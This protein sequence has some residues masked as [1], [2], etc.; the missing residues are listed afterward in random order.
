VVLIFNETSNMGINPQADEETSMSKVK[1]QLFAVCVAVLATV[2]AAG[3]SDT[4]N[5][6]QPPP[7]GTVV[8]SIVVTP[9]STSLDR[10]GAK[11]QFDAQAFDANGG[12]MSATFSWASTNEN[13]VVIG[14]GGL[15]AASGPGNAYIIASAGGAADS[16]SV[17]VTVGGSTVIAW[18]AGVNGN[19]DDATKWD[20]GEVPGPDDTAVIDAAGDYTV[21]MAGDVSIKSLILGDPTVGTPSLV[22]GTNTL[23]VEGGSING[24]A[25]LDVDGTTNITGEFDWRGGDIRGTG[26]VQIDPS[27]ELEIGGSGA[28]QDLEATLRNRGTVAVAE[29][30]SIDLRGGNIENSFGA[31]LDF[32]GDGIISTLAN[33]S[34]TN[35][36]SIQKSGGTGIASISASAGSFSTT[37]RVDVDSGTLALR[38]GTWRGVFDVD[39]DAQL[40]QTG[41]TEIISMETPGEGAIRFAGG[42]ALAPLSSNLVS[43]KHLI[44]DLGGGNTIDGPGGLEIYGSLLWR[45]GDVVGEGRMILSSVA[46]MP[47]EGTVNKRIEQRFFE[48]R[49]TVDGEGI[50]ELILEN[51]AELYIFYSGRWVQNGPGTI[52]NG[53]GDPSSIRIEGEFEKQGAGAFTFEP[54]TTCAG[55]MVLEGDA[56]AVTGAFQLAETGTI[57]GG[58]T[59][60]AGSNRKLIVINA[61][62]ASIAGTIALGIDDDLR[63][64]DIMGAVTLEPTFRLELD[65]NPNSAITHETLTFETGGIALAGT[66]DVTV[67]SFPDHGTQYR[68][69]AMTAGTGRF[70][71][72]TG[73][74]VFETIQQDANGVLLIKD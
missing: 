11:Q 6:T 4:T 12:E 39:T 46:S 10:L 52:R 14:S 63:R 67:R 61:P 37:G 2:Y 19:W 45:R 64:M 71:A 60:D 22:T 62:S 43:V 36:G 40:D 13:V 30:A 8:D 56:V 69:V 25:I 33:S 15:A 42:V 51:G 70:D 35:S 5:I 73:A 29:G 57:T 17:T 26:V 47:F 21:M 7:P 59:G 58:G 74:S 23:T 16:A 24:F 1:N 54:A 49:G 3:C 18:A 66:L 28:K 34:I 72:V 9:T 20:G 53:L 32:R 65:V 41:T 38:G 27:A 31:L 48:C 50:G 55:L 68:V 44:I